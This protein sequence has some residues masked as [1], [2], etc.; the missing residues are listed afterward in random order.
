[1]SATLSPAKYTF[2]HSTVLSKASDTVQRGFYPNVVFNLE[3]S[4][5]RKFAS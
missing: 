2:V 3:Q 1:M 4:S 5:F